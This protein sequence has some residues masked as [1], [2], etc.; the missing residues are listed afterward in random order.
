MDEQLTFNQQVESSRLSAV[1]V[2]S[3]NRRLRSEES[4]DYFAHGRRSLTASTTQVATS[5]S[6]GGEQAYDDR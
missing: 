4:Q 5:S 1:T 3:G 2:P 6:L